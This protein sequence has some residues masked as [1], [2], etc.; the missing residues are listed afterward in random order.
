MQQT[1]VLQGQTL[2]TKITWQAWVV[3]LS[4]SLFFFYEFVQI[5]MF[6]S[7]N[8]SIM[9]A[10]HVTAGATGRISSSYFYANI[11]FMFP[12]GMILDRYSTK[13]IIIIAMI[14]CLV[15]TFLFSLSH[16]VTQASLCRFLSGV[17]G[18][19]PFL[20]C[21]RLASR[22]FPARRLA[23]V[24]GV[25]VTV[26]M[27]G[28][29]AGQTP[30]VWLIS[31]VGW[32]HALQLD[33]LLGVIF[34][35]IIYC[36]VVDFPKH[37]KHAVHAS[38]KSVNL[39]QSIKQTLVNKQ[40]WIFGFYTCFLNLPIMLLG[41][42]WGGL[43]LVQIFHLSRTQASL[44]TSMIFIGTIFGSPV[45]GYISDLVGRRLLPMLIFGF[46]S[47]IIMLVIMF[48]GNL[49]F[50]SLLILFFLLGFI[51]SS[52][53]ISYPA[54]AES[55]SH[56]QAGSALGLASVVIMLGPAILQPLV[57][58]LLDLNWNHHLVNHVPQY[59]LHDFRLALSILPITLLIGTLLIFLA[60]E[61][62]CRHKNAVFNN[63]S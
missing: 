12:A 11:L 8:P 35:V 49:S 22:W 50:L 62:Y 16:N 57:G 47:V 55:N 15:G 31:V 40:N 5:M 7:I 23:L 60:Y 10:F 39:I 3:C 42:V 1:S 59:S 21:L 63:K 4:A 17:G 6:N 20:C 52:Q 51:T 18:S 36:T 53:V 46:I 14:L 37:F 61:T 38:K 32:R 2:E 43:Y 54:I 26:A 25:T 13:K 9:S 33:A 27:L 24:S 30:L 48:A 58:K 45:I 44:V 56:Q 19:F 41:A 28:G 29:V 34:T